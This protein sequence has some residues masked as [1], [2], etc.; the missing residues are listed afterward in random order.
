MFH[1]TQVACRDFINPQ[2]PD[3]RPAALTFSFWL[4]D[5][6]QK[7]EHTT[8]SQGQIYLENKP[9]C[10]IDRK[11]SVM[12]QTVFG[13]PPIHNL[14]KMVFLRAFA[15]I[16][17]TVD[18]DQPQWS[19]WR[20]LTSD[21][22]MGMGVRDRD[23][24]QPQE[25]DCSAMLRVAVRWL[26]GPASWN[27]YVLRLGLDAQATM[28][29]EQLSNSKRSCRLRVLISNT[30]LSFSFASEHWAL[31]LITRTQWGTSQKGQTEVHEI[32]DAMMQV[33]TTKES[34]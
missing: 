28:M 9:L 19:A 29:R 22:E 18:Q 2:R 4:P 17:P 20:A 31:A 14:F 32:V 10:E 1:F 24:D 26:R 11:C 5:G 8:K 33:I 7:V 21:N 27:L 30:M 34:T 12:M 6:H 23:D 16:A 13:H 3:D 15:S 25:G